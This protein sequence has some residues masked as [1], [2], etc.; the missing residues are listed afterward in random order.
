[1][2]YRDYLRVAEL[3]DHVAASEL[4]SARFGLSVGRLSIGADVA[5]DPSAVRQLV[6][7]GGHDL[8]IVRYPSQLVGLA[9]GL[10]DADLV[11]W[12]ADTLLYFENTWRA[13]PGRAAVTD[14]EARLVE[15]TAE[16]AGL[17]GAT[18]RE[19]FARYGNHYSANPCL[20]QEAALEGYVEWAV[21]SLRSPTRLALVLESVPDEVPLAL[22]T[23]DV[24][25]DV[26]E[27]ELAGVVP[28]S[29][30]RGIYRVLLD[31]VEDRL[32]NDGRTG[33]VISTQAGNRTPIR[34]W[35]GRGYQYALG[36]N[37]VHLMRAES[38]RRLAPR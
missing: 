14:G 29:R 34:A 12:Q 9:A 22:C 25:A 19:V 4:E 33:V 30:G 8:T 24:Q 18:V 6:L 28:T 20:D 15:M 2:A 3:P 11:G 5:T 36:L 35:I 16:R 31:H 13:T 23:L 26:A 27:I 10:L 1:M 21:G 37:T 17:L 32:R 38:F 7:A